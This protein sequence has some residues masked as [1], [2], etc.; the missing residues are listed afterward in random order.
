MSQSQRQYPLIPRTRVCIC[1][2]RTATPLYR[3]PGEPNIMAVCATVY[4]KG[5]GKAV[6]RAAPKTQ[7]CEECFIK[8]LAPA[9]FGMSRE[10][11][12]LL[13]HIRQSLSECYSS[14]LDDDPD[15]EAA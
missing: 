10:A 4:R 12:A 2:E 11:K 8:A 6:L 7:I 13:L 15:P 3:Q 5:N 1:C 14:L 9:T